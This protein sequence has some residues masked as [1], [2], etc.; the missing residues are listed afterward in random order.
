MPGTNQANNPSNDDEM[1]YLGSA[2]LLKGSLPDK[3][4]DPNFTAVAVGTSLDGDS[5]A[6]D[7][8]VAYHDPPV[9]DRLAL[10]NHLHREYRADS[11]EAGSEDMEVE[12]KEE[13]DTVKEE[14]DRAKSA[15]SSV[16]DPFSGPPYDEPE[17]PHHDQEWEEAVEFGS[18]S[19]IVLARAGE[20]CGEGCY[21]KAPWIYHFGDP[22]PEFDML[23]MDQIDRLCRKLHI[24]NVT[25]QPR[26]LAP[27]HGPLGV[28]RVKFANYIRELQE[29]LKHL[30]NRENISRWDPI[31][32]MLKNGSSPDPYT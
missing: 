31:H 18:N 22:V 21:R 2:V 15:V 25:G 10:Q 20:Y 17:P 26:L 24:N 13:E 23:N 12:E 29:I 1:K 28:L 6:P 5:K 4:R 9:G 32:E 27:V 16:Y 8:S 3:P 14:A 30:P 11:K 7:D 19:D